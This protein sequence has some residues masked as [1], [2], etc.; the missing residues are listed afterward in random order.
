MRTYL[1]RGLYTPHFAQSYRIWAQ[2]PETLKIARVARRK[3][4]ANPTVG[5][6]KKGGLVRRVYRCLI[7]SMYWVGGNSVFTRGGLAA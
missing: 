2:K 4:N 1:P 3:R 6:G 7:L 5:P